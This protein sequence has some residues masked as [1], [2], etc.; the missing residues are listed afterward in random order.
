MPNR[1]AP[2]RPPSAESA[3]RTSTQFRREGLPC[4]SDSASPRSLRRRKRHRTSTASPSRYT[5]STNSPGRSQARISSATKTRARSVK[6]ITC[7]RE[8]RSTNVPAIG[9]KSENG[10]TRQTNKM[11]AAIGEASETSAHKAQAGNK[12]EPVS[13]LRNELPGKQITK[14]AVP[15][16]QLSVRDRL[17]DPK[18]INGT[19]RKRDL[20]K[21]N[22]GTSGEAP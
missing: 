12:I 19:R 2:T 6:I 8:K 1:Q 13:K 15:S 3:S 14:I 21:N 11:P 7:R 22:F 10:S 18:R 17:H 4:R 20:P 16:Q 5:R 9:E